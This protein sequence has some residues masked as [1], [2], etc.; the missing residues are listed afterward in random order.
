MSKLLFYIIAGV[1]LAPV[2]NVLNK[3]FFADWEFLKFLMV[4][5]G[6]DTITGFW[7]AVKRRELSSRAWG[8]VIE[9]VIVYATFVIVIHVLV[10]YRVSGAPVKVFAWLNQVAYAALMAKEAL[11]IV[12]NLGAI[13]NNLLPRWVLR[14]LR[15]FDKTGKFINTNENDT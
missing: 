12:E 5:I 10:H 14:W 3:Y 9:K 2:M 13:N 11:S 1:T 15:E 6:L 7:R 8:G 4:L